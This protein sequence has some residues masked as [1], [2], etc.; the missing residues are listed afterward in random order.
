MAGELFTKA[1]E[2]AGLSLDE[3]ARELKIRTGFLSALE[4]GSFE[5]LPPDVYARGYIKEYA[6]YLGIPP[7]PLLEEYAKRR[8]L[9]C[10]SGRQERA[11][12]G[13]KISLRRMSL[14]VSLVF[15]VFTFLY[16]FSLGHR[17]PDKTPNISKIYTLPPAQEELRGSISDN[18]VTA[19]TL[20]ALSEVLPRENRLTLT[21]L[22]TSWIRIEREGK[23]DEEV[24]LKANESREWTSRN[25]FSLK[26]GNAGGVK[27]TLNGSDLG[28]PGEKG[29]VLR[30]RLP[31]EEIPQSSSDA[32]R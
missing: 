21:A 20:P 23:K 22:E 6:Q 19:T 26:I 8:I 5:K 15:A 1:R 29:R 3:V 31:K 7:E 4:N 30:L 25:E 18:H 9:L 10:T 17:I 13:K 11:S 28:V 32:R 14:I 27:I 24:L 2:E 16:L 12:V